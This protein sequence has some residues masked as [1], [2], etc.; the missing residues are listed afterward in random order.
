MMLATTTE[1]TVKI[2]IIQMT[3]LVILEN[4]LVSFLLIL[5]PPFNLGFENSLQPFF[6]NCKKTSN[7]NA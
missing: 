4:V 5:A 7:K 3:T 6:L 1:P 2:N